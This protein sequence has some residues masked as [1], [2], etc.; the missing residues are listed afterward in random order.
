M[1]RTVAELEQLNGKP[2]L[3]YPSAERQCWSEPRWDEGRLARQLG[4]DVEMYFEDPDRAFTAGA[5][6]MASSEKAFAGPHGPRIDRLFIFLLSH[7]RTAP[8]NDWVIVPGK[9][10]GPIPM[11]APVEP[12]R[13]TL[14]AAQVHRVVTPADEGL[15]QIPGI[16][17]FAD[18]TGREVLLRRDGH[19]V[20]GGVGQYK[21][22]RWRIAGSVPLKTTVRELE[23]LNGRPFVFNGCCFDLGGIV[24]SWEGGKL[25]SLLRARFAVSCE[26]S[27]P[28]R[29]TGDGTQVRSDDPDIRKQKCTVEVVNF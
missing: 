16:S 6:Y 24:T 27:Q 11:D 18:L 9:R 23:R 5:G 25:E 4:E 3:L 2:F 26:G 1:G 29:L 15:G 8:A 14:G 19:L 12:L 20:C 22:C 21:T 10:L 13:E 17:V 7:G 28:A